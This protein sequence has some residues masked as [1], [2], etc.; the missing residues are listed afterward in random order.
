MGLIGTCLAFSGIV[1]VLSS[2][3]I[4]QELRNIFGD[5]IVAKPITVFFV[6]GALLVGSSVL[7]LG[8][9]FLQG[10]IRSK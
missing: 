9:R 1:M 8:G 6:F 3:G 10:A 5:G 2:F 4:K 7:A